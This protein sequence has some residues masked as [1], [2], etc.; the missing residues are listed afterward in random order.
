VFYNINIIIYYFLQASG[1]SFPGNF[2][3]M[4]EKKTRTRCVSAGYV[5]F[6]IIIIIIIF[7]FLVFALGSKDPEG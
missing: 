7:F 1:T 6:I 5:Q 4:N 2:E 3:I